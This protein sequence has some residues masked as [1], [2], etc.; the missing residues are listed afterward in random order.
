MLASLAEPVAGLEGALRRLLAMQRLDAAEALI[1]DDEEVV[2]LGADPDQLR[3]LVRDRRIAQEQEARRVQASLAGRARAAGLDMAGQDSVTTRLEVVSSAERDRANALRAR[4]KVRANRD[5]EFDNLVKECI[6]AGEFAAAE[7]LLDSGPGT[8]VFGGPASVRRSPKWPYP[9]PLVNVLP[10]YQAGGPADFAVRRPAENDASGWALIEAL[11]AVDHELDD[12][13]AQRLGDAIDGLCSDVRAA[14][15]PVPS[16][17]GYVVRLR[18][19]N[20]LRLGWLGLDSP[21]VTHIGHEPPTESNVRIWVDLGEGARRLRAP[22]VARVNVRFLLALVAPGASG[23]PRLS[24]DRRIN[25]IREVCWQLPPSQVVSAR[26]GDLGLWNEAREAVL[27]MFDLLGLRPDPGVADVILYDTAGFPDAVTALVEAVANRVPR[28]GDVSMEQLRDLRAD[29]VTVGWIRARIANQIQEDP[30]AAVV[31]GALLL[32]C[33]R[34]PDSPVSVE[35]LRDELDDMSLV[36][37]D[38]PPPTDRLDLLGGLLRIR[39]LGL[40]VSEVSGFR[41]V[42]PGLAALLADDGL[43]EEVLENLTVVHQRWNDLRDMASRAQQVRTKRSYDHL[44]KNYDYAHQQLVARLEDPGLD[45]PTQRQISRQLGAQTR[46]MTALNL[47]ESGDLS[48]LLDCSPFDLL[49]LVQDFAFLYQ[50]TD[51]QLVVEIEDR[52][53]QPR[54]PIYGAPQLMRLALDDLAMNAMQAMDREGSESR[55]FRLTVTCVN[56]E[57]DQ[58]AVVDIEDSGPGFPTGGT[59]QAE[60]EARPGVAG[61]DGLMNVRHC[62]SLSRGEFLPQDVPSPLGG[63]HLKIRIPVRPEG[64]VWSTDGS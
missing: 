60:R 5:Q 59:A 14:H 41:L 49:E 17:G 26:P 22:G 61:G 48:Q 50:V 31:L 4:L 19:L 21:T 18:A 36:A 44:R 27:W 34:E 47:M 51:P 55:T 43:H 13:T 11:R 29:P 58:I 46:R 64:P 6:R 45:S 23:R 57:V 28:P 20:D 12:E 30:N 38:D 24:A 52:T 42:G 39:A 8:D 63:A 3:E 16:A 33:S 54:M 9:E 56:E 53:G 37:F 7:N 2:S 25:L 1:A 10:W 40:T 15:P 62:L 32:R 35:D